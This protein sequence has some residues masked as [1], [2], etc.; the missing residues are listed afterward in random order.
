MAHD[1]LS[2]YPDFNETFKI[3]TDASDFQLGLVIIQKGTPITLYGRKHTG[4]QKSYTVT[5][6]EVLRII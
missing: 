4:A 5:E 6:N 2:D 3:H 1:N